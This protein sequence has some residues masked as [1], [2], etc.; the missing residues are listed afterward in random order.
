MKILVTG[1]TGLVGK[2]LVKRLCSL[3]HE[4][5]ATTRNADKAKSLLPSEAKIV[6][7]ENFYTLPPEEAIN[8]INAVVHLMGENIGRKRW[9]N[10]QKKILRDSRVES[11]KNILTALK[12]K[13]IKLDVFITSSAIGIY[14]VNSNK[15]MNEE[16]FLASGFLANLCKEWEEASNDTSVVNRHVAIRTGVVLGLNEGAM[17]KMLPIFKL[18][19]GGPIGDGNQMMSWIHVDDLVEVFVKSLETK[20]ISGAI[21]A[22]APKAVDNFTFSKSLGKAL[23][24]PSLVLT[25]TF[26]LKIVFGEMSTI[27]LDSQHV[28]PKKLKDLS[29]N[30]KYPDIDSAFTNL[31]SQPQQ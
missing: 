28:E 3:G 30:F 10:E 15:V 25:P 17:A 11:A 31:Y 1:A 24:R 19:I 12:N 7:W 2:K 16:T 23:K 13:N 21:N 8:G 9:S 22:V 5:V 26:P 6:E 29:F 4:V 18:G 27:I 14:P 20:D